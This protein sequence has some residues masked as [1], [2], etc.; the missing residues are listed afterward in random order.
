MGNRSST[1]LAVNRKHLATYEKLLNMCFDDQTSFNISKKYSG[2]I[3]KCVEAFS[4]I[5]SDHVIVATKN[6]K[7][8]HQ[9][10]ETYQ[11]SRDKKQE[12][13]IERSK[14]P[15]EEQFC[16]YTEKMEELLMDNKNMLVS[17]INE[18]MQQHKIMYDK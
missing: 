11:K 16:S 6:E 14:Q 7:I 9:P 8:D 5:K 4:K 13:K 12:E 1:D 10:D 2:N 18:K 3:N 17:K 15:T